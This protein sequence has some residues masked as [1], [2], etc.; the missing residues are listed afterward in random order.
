MNALCGIRRFDNADIALSGQMRE[1][2]DFSSPENKDAYRSSGIAIRFRTFS[3][4]D[5]PIQQP[6]ISPLGVAIAWDGRLD[7]REELLSALARKVSPTDDD[8]ALVAAAYERWNTQCFQR[9]VGDWAVSIWDP[10]DRSVLLARDFIG[11]KHLYYSI[12]P[13]LFTWSTVLEPLVVHREHLLDFE[14][15]AGWLS[16]YPATTLTPYREVHSVPPACFLRVTAGELK[17]QQYWKFDGSKRIRYRTDREY[18]EHFRMVFEQAIRRRLRSSSPVLAELSGG[19]DSSAI[20]AMA[21]RIAATSAG[22]PRIDTVSYYSDTEPNWDERQ[23]FQKM[24]ERRGRSGLHIDV[25]TTPVPEISGG[26]PIAFWPG[27]QPPSTVAHWMSQHGQRVLLSGIGGDEFLG[28]V[29]TPIP[30][31]EDLFARG[32]F[33]KLAQLL[34]IW[35]L[36]QRRPWIYLLRDVITG[37]LPLSVRPRTKS[38]NAASWLRAEFV[39]KYSPTMNGYDRRWTIFGVLPTFQEN[40][41]AL[42]KIRRQLTATEPCAEC[43]YERR[44]PYLDRDL[45]EFLFAIPREQLVRP[46][47]RRSLMRRALRDVVPEEILNRR[48]KAYAT[49]TPLKTIARLQDELNI[50]DLATASLKIVVPEM[51]VTKLEEAQQGKEIPIVPLLRTLALERWLQNLR[52]KGYLNGANVKIEFPLSETR[53]ECGTASSPTPP[54]LL[55]AI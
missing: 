51:L 2:F 55:T 7:N 25:G 10:R 19:M 20:V 43:P 44:Y 23:Y 36:I 32:H 41:G 14:Y 26:N 31:L 37:F 50:H 24:E 52:A 15:M 47:E 34:K 35:A 1:L 3:T 22:L 5:D 17:I 11:I 39:Q 9:L 46:G 27:S 13:E 38:Q 29:P 18:E 12:T 45:L 28:G 30:E 16:S 48:R 4:R 40:L 49:L 21:D 54:S 8:V 42:E 53:R 6:H 33:L